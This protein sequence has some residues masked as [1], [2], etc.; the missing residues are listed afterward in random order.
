MCRSTITSLDD[1][2]MIVPTCVVDGTPNE[3]LMP[4]KE[5]IICYEP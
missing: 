1:E 4:M 2:T 5:G 3:Y